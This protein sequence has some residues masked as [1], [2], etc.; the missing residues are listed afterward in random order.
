[1]SNVCA[2]CRQDCRLVLVDYGIG[3]YEYW[4]CRGV[5]VQWC[6]VSDC[7]EAGVLH[8]VWA[9]PDVIMESDVSPCDW[10]VV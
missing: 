7:C 5:D 8:D 2:A 4:G 9:D 6:E 10:A 1:V 3:S